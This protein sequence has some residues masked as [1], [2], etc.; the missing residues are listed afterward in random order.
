MKISTRE[1]SCKK[2]MTNFR[3]CYVF[4]VVIGFF[5]CRPRDWVAKVTSFLQI[6]KIGITYK[7]MSDVLENR[8]LA[9]PVYPVC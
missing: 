2:A 6:L 7:I 4:G 1:K 5:S 3:Y 8:S 9:C